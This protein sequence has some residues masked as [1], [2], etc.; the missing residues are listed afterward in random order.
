VSDVEYR[1]DY[2]ISRRGPGDDD[3]KEIGFGGSCGAATVNAAAYD[4]KS[5]IQNRNW[6][7]SGDMPDPSAVDEE[8]KS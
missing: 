8:A 3:F 2:T 6:E 4:V 7:T 5:D 1:I